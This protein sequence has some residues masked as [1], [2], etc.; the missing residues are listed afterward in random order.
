VTNQQKTE[1]GKSIFR[2]TGFNSICT[3][4]AGI[5][6]YQAVS[7]NL[8]ACLPLELCLRGKSTTQSYRAPTYYVDHCIR[9]GMSLEDAIA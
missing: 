1:H 7:G 5:N 3:L 4:A 9:E 6:Y 2:A 8:L